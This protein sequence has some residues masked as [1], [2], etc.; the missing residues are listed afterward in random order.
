MET[1]FE[2]IKELFAQIN[3]TFYGVD[4]Y[5]QDKKDLERYQDEQDLLKVNE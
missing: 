1:N 5:D 3:K 2:S 4:P